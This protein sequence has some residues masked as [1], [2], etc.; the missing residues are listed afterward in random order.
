MKALITLGRIASLAAVHN[1]GDLRDQWLKLR[2]ANPSGVASIGDRAA[3]GNEIFWT[4][5]V[6]VKGIVFLFRPSRVL[7]ALEKL[8]HT[9][10]RYDEVYLEA[11]EVMS[12][13]ETVEWQP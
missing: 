12:K 4:E 6:K 13:E 7:T 5:S 1:L 2:Q 3:A 11:M 8:R 10:P 9:P